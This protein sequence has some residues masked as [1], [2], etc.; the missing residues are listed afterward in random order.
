MLAAL[1]STKEAS[2]A[3][4]SM[5]DAI[6]QPQMTQLRR[7]V[8]VSVDRGLTQR[9]LRGLP[10]AFDDLTREFD[11]ALYERMLYDPQV[12][13]CLN[14]LR[15]AVI[16]EGVRCECAVE[17]ADDDGYELAHEIAAFC[18]SVLADLPIGMDDVLW[19][20]LGAVATGSRVAE[21]VWD[22][23]PATTYA[24]PGTSPISRTPD[25]LVLSALKPRPRR[26][27][28]FVV[29]PYMNVVGL[30]ARTDALQ[31][32]SMSVVADNVSQ[33]PNLFP[34]E[35]FAVLS[36]RPQNGDPRGTSALRQAYSPWWAKM[37][38]WPE[39]LRYLAQ[40]ASASVYAV[41]SE[42]A[43]KNGIPV[44]QTDGSTLIKPATEVLR[45]ALLD[46]KNGTALA[47]PYGTLLGA[48]QAVGNGE[49]FHNGFTFADE[50]ITIAI[51]HQT[52]ATREGQHQAR[53]ASEEHANTLE[54]LQHQLKRT[55][56]QM[57]RRDILCPL[58]EYNY[59]PDVARQ[60]TPT[61]S[62]GA[63]EQQDFSKVATAISLL[64]RAGYLDPSQFAG[65]DVMLS[66]PERAEMTPQDQ[67]A[68]G[69]GGQSPAGDAAEETDEQ[70]QGGMDT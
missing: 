15:S 47:V 19:D 7:E 56:A 29:D 27:T 42:Q 32:I 17:D 14:V 70:D 48:L 44:L 30:I 4:D 16:E 68:Q 25:L 60:L 41:A 52:L 61:C 49:A 31:S 20:M 40:F 35:K 46:Y 67:Q 22:L 10:W 3:F 62:L 64:A 55:V 23:R 13:A 26:S 54:T 5:T 11:D 59:G 45:D 24:L 57:V 12:M 38:I 65:I 33:V 53:A 8:V 21:K 6:P 9:G 69:Q 43:T 28:A 2:A 1:A 50:Q 58:V 34:R 36:F 51:L 39:F 63:V 66:L 18:E 37:Q